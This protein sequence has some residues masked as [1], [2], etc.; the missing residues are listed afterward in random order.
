MTE[1]LIFIDFESHYDP[2][3]YSLSKMLTAEY[4]LDKRFELL[5]MSVALNDGEVEY[6]ES[7][8]PLYLRAAVSHLP[9]DEA[10]VVAHNAIFDGAVLEWKLR[11][12]PRRYFCTMMA[13]RPVHATKVRSMSLDSLTKDFDVG[14]KKTYILKSLGGKRLRDMNAEERVALQKYGKH[15]TVL[16]R[17]LYHELDS[18]IPDDEREL[19]DLTV[20][21]FVQPQLKLDHNLL[22]ARLDEIAQERAEVISAAGVPEGVL[23]SNPKFAAELERRGV[24]PPMKKS[25]TTGEMTYAFAKSDLDF[26]ALAGSPKKGVKELVKARLKAKSTIERSRVERLLTLTKMTRWLPAPTLYY[27]AHTGRWSGMDSLNLQNLP[28][29]G[30]LRQ[31]I[32]APPG[33]VVLAGDLSQIEARMLATLAGCTHLVEQF[34][35]GEDTYSRFASKVFN[36]EVSKDVRPDLRF[37][38]KTAILGLGYGLGV[39]KFLLTMQ[40]AGLDMDERGAKRVVYAYREMYPQIPILWST[41]DDIIMQSLVVPGS[42]RALGPLVFAHEHVALPNQMTLQYPGLRYSSLERR[43][44][45][46]DPKGGRKT[47]YGGKLTENIVQ[48]LA[49]IVLSAAELRLARQGLRAALTVHD[50]LV[51]VVPEERVREVYDKVTEELT[52]PVPWLPDL[53]LACEVK[54]GSSYGECK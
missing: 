52:R 48:A 3:T 13:A 6:Y 35:R 39:N 29:G 8:D 9:W 54:Y 14:P 23:M 17:H 28:R 34:E 50:E 26:L 25:P 18:K 49:R 31:A 19:I 7:D 20:R 15:D 2:K 27:G 16:M 24:M 21:K 42:L 10:T 36:T 47:L 40:L 53:P 51:Y 33:H 46:F 32:V 4:V 12:R 11:I 45:Y 44:T 41:L 43:F 38:G 5:G 30:A 22:V 1:P 37:V